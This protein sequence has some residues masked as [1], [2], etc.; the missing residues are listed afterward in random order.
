MKQQSFPWLEQSGE[1]LQHAGVIAGPAAPASGAKHAA[2]LARQV[3]RLPEKH[4]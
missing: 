3:Q 4:G 2:T 1:S